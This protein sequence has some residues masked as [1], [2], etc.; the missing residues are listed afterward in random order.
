MIQLLTL[1][2]WDVKQ[3]EVLSAAAEALTA[4]TDR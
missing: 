3:T 2:K 1:R 4:D